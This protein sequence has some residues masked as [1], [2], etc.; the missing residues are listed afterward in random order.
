NSDKYPS[1]PNFRTQSHEEHL[2]Q[3]NSSYSYKRRPFYPTSASRYY[4]NNSNK[5]N[6]STNN[7][8]YK[9][10][11][12][13]DNKENDTMKPLFN[14]DDYTRITTPRQDVL[15]KKGYLSRPKK[16]I[17]TN[18]SS[19]TT[20]SVLSTDDS[21]SSGTQSLS[22]EHCSSTPEVFDLDHP[23]MYPGFYDQNG[24]F[25]VN[26]FISNGFDPYDGQMILMPYGGSPFSINPT[27]YCS[28]ESTPPYPPNHYEKRDSVD[29]ENS[30][31]SPSS[32]NESASASASSTPAI[33]ESSN[34]T[35][36]NGGESQCDSD[37]PKI[38]G[39][40]T[41]NEYY[42]VPMQFYYPLMYGPP[43][44]M[45]INEMNYNDNMAQYVNNYGEKYNRF[46]K[47]K[48]RPYKCGNSTGVSAT[49]TDYSEDEDSIEENGCDMY[50]STQ[51]DNINT[52][53]TLTIDQC[54]DVITR[55]TLNTNVSE[56]VPR[57]LK[58][59]LSQITFNVEV[60]EF[61][62]RNYSP[63]LQSKSTDDPTPIEAIT[64]EVASESQ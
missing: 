54:D 36:Q 24:V 43:P 11:D 12:K 23:L 25:F 53:P 35:S 58:S 52:K 13:L 57:H 14:E 39:E 19:S 64:K 27:E 26:P 28:N 30:P 49:T 55:T 42:N 3:N 45:S 17:E 18:V 41:S 51:Q 9:T 46:R 33:D 34:E 44:F 62:P 38:E 32:Q 10:T 59:S 56:F 50:Q 2:H 8:L 21:I 7:R 5:T 37:G 60:E 40:L 22:P 63:V 29:S 20:I 15:F 6:C 48:R 47:R 31:K 61:R 1:T 4:G 16:T